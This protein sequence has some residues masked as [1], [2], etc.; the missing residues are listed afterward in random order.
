M[1][2][3]EPFLK[4]KPKLNP[5]CVLSDKHIITFVA[6]VVF[7][8]P[9]VQNGMGLY[10]AAFMFFYI[11]YVAIRLV[12]ANYKFSKTKYLFFE[13]KVVILK[14]YGKHSE[15]KVLYSDIAD[16]KLFQTYLQ[17][18][19]HIGDI[20]IILKNKNILTNQVRLDSLNNIEK[21]V[22]DLQHIIYD[23]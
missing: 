16:I 13:K 4:L 7:G 9:I 15:D 10:Y 6:L 22:E 18:F 19:F 12:I 5:L 14:R 21:V 2:K 11:A 17:K 1:E 23:K 20:V 3:I 8:I